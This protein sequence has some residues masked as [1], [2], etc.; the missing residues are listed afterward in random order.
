MAMG[1]TS[2]GGGAP[3]AEGRSGSAKV[4]VSVMDGSD[5]RFAFHN[6]FCC[7]PPTKITPASDYLFHLI[8]YLSRFPQLARMEAGTIE[9][10]A[11]KEWRQGFSFRFID[12]PERVIFGALSGFEAPLPMPKQDR[13][14]A[15][16]PPTIGQ[17]H[18]C[19]PFKGSGPDMSKAASRARWR[20]ITATQP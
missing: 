15:P 3:S 11:Q 4:L 17:A 19:D 2:E 13:C 8:Q 18:D 12:T 20:R 6:G 16:G 5:S 9:A 1:R 10:R 14:P 7:F